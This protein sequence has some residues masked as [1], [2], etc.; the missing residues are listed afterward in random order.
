[1]ISFA[2][3]VPV[4]LLLLS[5]AA[6]GYCIFR[7]TTRRRLRLVCWLL[8]GLLAFM[9]ANPV[10]ILRRPDDRTGRV[11]VL[12]DSSLSMGVRDAGSGESRFAAADEFAR[13]LLRRLGNDVPVT[14]FD[15][16]WQLREEHANE[17]AGAAHFR[18]A[19]AA[20]D[21][22]YGAGALAATVL[23]TDG[24][25]L[26]GH[27]VESSDSPVFAVKFGSELNAAP[28]LSFGEFR[29]PETARAGASLDLRIPVTLTGFEAPRQVEFKLLVDGE[30]AASERFELRPGETRQIPVKAEL[31]MAGLHRLTFE[32]APLPGEVTALDNRRTAAVDAEPDSRF[33]LI[34]FARLS[35]GFRPLVRFFT[36][37]KADFTALYPAG[38]AGGVRRIGSNA[39]KGFENG[40]PTM[41]EAL[42]PV[43]M[44]I[45]GDFDESAGSREQLAAVESYVEQGGTLVLLGGADSFSVTPGSPAARLLPFT[46]SAQKLPDVPLEISAPEESPFAGRFAPGTVRGL[47]AV[48]S[49]KPGASVLLQA[50]EFPLV[51][52]MPYGRGQVAAI[53]SPSLPLW[54][55][56]A[57]ERD[58]NFGAFLAELSAWLGSRAAAQWRVELL[59]ALPLPGEAVAIRVT[60]PPDTEEVIGS[61][62]AGD[63][64]A[65]TILFRRQKSGNFLGAVTFPDGAAGELEI[66]ARSKSRPEARRVVPVAVGKAMEESSD[67]RTLDGNFRRIASPERI[68]APA[69]LDRLAADLAERISQSATERD[70]RPVFETIWFLA[71]ALLLAGL[72]WFMRRRLH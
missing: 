37:S 52:A 42:K 14:R 8:A 47:R 62:S 18:G 64:A 38:A 2:P 43:G 25:D 35:T 24:G 31:A 4:W 46:P 9:A 30:P 32:L 69:D 55:K 27:R 59:P 5:L 20:L 22:R 71:A 48:E 54:G 39:G 40:L 72:I 60:P 16:D 21:R 17:P 50:G 29:V 67:L 65:R 63:A 57:S 53:L 36:R 41:A 33:T 6:V 3:L 13:Q 19:F 34:S 56:N 44:L 10:V 28:N 12:V 66:L 1:M 23:L 11:A 7:T 26:S 68:Y 49:L 70:F 58:A 51:V 61:F 45:L 15:F